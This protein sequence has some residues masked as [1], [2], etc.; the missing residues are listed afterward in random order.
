MAQF[1]VLSVEFD[2]SEVGENQTAELR[3]TIDNPQ[4]MELDGAATHDVP[5]DVE[6]VP[7][8]QSPSQQFWVHQNNY[9]LTITLKT[10]S[11]TNPLVLS[12]TDYYNFGPEPNKLLDIVTAEKNDNEKKTRTIRRNVSG[13]ATT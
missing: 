9:H 7:S 13:V 1:D 6:Q 3:V 11:G 4:N 12:S 2:F 8:G 5:S 10:G